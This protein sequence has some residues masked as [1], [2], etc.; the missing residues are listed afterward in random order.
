M[1]SARRSALL[2]MLLAVLIGGAVA[3]AQPAHADRCQP[4]ELLGYNPLIPEGDSPVCQVLI[5]QVYPAVCAGTATLA[6]CTAN[7]DVAG[8]GDTANVCVVSDFVGCAYWAGT[9]GVGVGEPGNGQPVFGPVDVAG[10][11]EQSK[12]CAT[13]DFAG[14]E[15]CVGGRTLVENPPIRP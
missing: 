4:E 1:T 14:S 5:D 6:Q 12:A 3:S 13:Y 7:L 2:G 15:M 11:T 8:T 10:I 9:G